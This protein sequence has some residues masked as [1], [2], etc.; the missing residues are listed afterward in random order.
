MDVRRWLSLD[1]TGADA[2][3][4]TRLWLLATATYG[5]GDVVTTVA[6]VQYAPRVS[7]GNPLVAVSIERF[8]L[9]GLVGLKW[10]AFFGALA[11]SLAAL[12]HWRDRTLSYYPP[13]TL[14]VVGLLVT[15]LNIGLLSMGR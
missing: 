4:F 2:E 10:L 13:L 15:V 14:A 5:V 8:G 7:E 9:G 6:L 11:V 12:H 3:R 1:G